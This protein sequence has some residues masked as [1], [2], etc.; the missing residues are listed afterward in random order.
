MLDNVYVTQ[1][2]GLQ[3]RLVRAGADLLERDG[4]GGVGLR[5]ITREVGVSHGA[6]RRYFPTHRDLLAAVARSGFDDLIASF[7]PVF[8]DDRSPKYTLIE[9]S[10]RFVRFAVD[11]PAMFD[12]MFR[13]DLL[14]GATVDGRPLR[15]TTLPLFASLIDL[16]AAAVPNRADAADRTLA[17]WTNVHGIA[18]LAANRSVDLV[19]GAADLPSLIE[20]AVQAHLRP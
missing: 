17:L 11:R 10:T 8:A 13:H 14:D 3:Q 19:S 2:A 12:L 16:V 7:A 4:L 1:Q 20:R 15:R 9:L 6:P 18:V 5:A